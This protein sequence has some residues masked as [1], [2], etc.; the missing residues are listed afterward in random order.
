MKNIIDKIIFR[1][2]NLKPLQY[3]DDV[4]EM[5]F[6]EKFIQNVLFQNIFGNFLYGP[7]IYNRT[8]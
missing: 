2:F 7:T 6:G 3:Y 8:A 1:P 4:T 5:E